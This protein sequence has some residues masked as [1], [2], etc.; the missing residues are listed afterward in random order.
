MSAE[1]QEVPEREETWKILKGSS[2]LHRSAKQLLQRRLS[3]PDAERQCQGSV[4]LSVRHAE[5]SRKSATVS[6]QCVGVDFHYVDAFIS[7]LLL[8]ATSHAYSYK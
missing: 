7:A 3:S 5:G 6:L 4:K 8:L 1:T 2:Q